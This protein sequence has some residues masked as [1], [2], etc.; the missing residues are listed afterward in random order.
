VKPQ[1][2]KFLA[3]FLK[4]ESGLVL[5]AEKT[6]LV[7]SRLVPVARRRGLPGLDEL[8][9]AV[10]GGKDA[11]LRKDVVEAMTTNE[12][13]FFRDIKPFESLKDVVLPRV[14]AARRAQK[15]AKIRIWSAACSSG[16]EPYTIAMLL[17]EN[18]PLLQGLAVEIVGTDLSTD[19]LAKA[20]E[21]VYTQFEAQRGLPIQLLMKHFHQVGEHWRINDA[22]RARVDYRQANLLRD[23]SGL[24][25]FDIVFCRNVL[26]Y[27]DQP[28]KSE[29]L[30]RIRRMMPD[31]GYLF[32]G[33][34]ETVIGVT[35]SFE[36]VKGERGVYSAAPVKAGAGVAKPAAPVAA[37][38]A[39]AAKPA[40]RPVAKAG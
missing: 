1:D 31:D 29:V 35:D 26:I 39:A 22:M 3:D 2:F 7:E 36:T 20:K 16:Q 32:L 11:Q 25:R 21:G 38:A 27:F 10:R 23:M 13:F 14:V 8:V 17:A 24:G 6:Y 5:S 12:S 34:A 28:T 37:A 33:G 9:E 18:A 19:I 4:A 30:E 15:A 40:V